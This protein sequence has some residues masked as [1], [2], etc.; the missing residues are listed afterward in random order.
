MSTY[1]VQTVLGTSL[2]VLTLSATL[3][4][5]SDHASLTTFH[6]N[7]GSEFHFLG[8]GGGDGGGGCT[9]LT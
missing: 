2:A 8:G 5:H 3:R 4:T 6:F 7:V 9:E 1:C